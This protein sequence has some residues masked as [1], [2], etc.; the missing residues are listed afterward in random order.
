M[1]PDRRGHIRRPITPP[2]YIAHVLSPTGTLVGLAMPADV[3]RS[4]FR[5]DT[6][7]YLNVGDLL[8]LE[9][10]RPH[11]LGGRRFPFVVVWS[12]PGVEIG[13]AFVTE[14]T[15]AETDALASE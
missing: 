14:I 3:S 2:A 4:G 5:I 7:A 10:Q 1:I 15:E 13:A 8:T 11:P 9:P 12:R 6:S